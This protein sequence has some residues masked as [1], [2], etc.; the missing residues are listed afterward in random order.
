[1]LI[2]EVLIDFF[3]VVVVVLAVV[4]LMELLEEEVSAVFLMLFPSDFYHMTTDDKIANV[5]ANVKEEEEVVE[6]VSLAL[7]TVVYQLHS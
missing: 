2:L 1:M 3:V 7:L 6:E 5:K 4:V